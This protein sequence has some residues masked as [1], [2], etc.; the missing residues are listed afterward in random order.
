MREV[1]VRVICAVIVAVIF[2]SSIVAVRYLNTDFGEVDT[3]QV[4][5]ASQLGNI[6]GLL[7]RPVYATATNPQPAVVLAHGI[8]GSKQYLSGIALELARNNIVAL[9]IDLLGHGGSDG[10]LADGNEDASLGMLAAVRYL[11]AQDFVNSSAIGLVGHSLGAGAARATAVA[12]EGIRATVLIAGGFGSM[13]A[14]PVYGA[15]NSTFPQNLL[16]A[17]GKYD[18]LFNL[19]ELKKETLPPIFETPTEAATDTLYGNFS[20]HNARKLVT[21]PTTHLFEPVDP[22]IGSET[23]KWL[24]SALQPTDLDENSRPTAGLSVYRDTSILI[25]LVTLLG[26]LLLISTTVFS[27]VHYPKIKRNIQMRTKAQSI[28]DWKVLIV[29][30]SLS[31]ILFFPMT[32]VGLS[33]NIPPVIFGS[34][35]AWWTLAIA[36]TGLIVV[37]LWSRFSNSELNVRAALAQAFDI[38]ALFAAVLIFV[39]LYLLATFVSTYMVIDFG[40]IVPFFRALTPSTRIPVFLMFIPFFFVYFTVEGIYL[41]ELRQ[42]SWRKSAVLTALANLAKTVGVKVTP[43]LVV[44][45]LQ[46]VPFVLFG[47]QLFPSFAGFLIEFLWLLIPI[48]AISTACSWWFYR[49][50]TRIGLG[51]VFNALV[52]AWIAASLFPF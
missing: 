9:T 25:G 27:I 49:S 10:R 24:I 42:P 45:S 12:H 29:W 40:I 28:R 31:L 1:N 26:L 23:I 36:A 17:I 20:S 22:V 7:Y 47:F 6:S 41:H 32:L 38:K 46:Y 3:Q 35:I 21:P 44:L 16:V 18:V 34:S 48:F 5:V 2:V 14:D 51:A 33:I 50:T 11:E 4:S 15:F 8:S 13:V 43:Y 30:G 52:F 19:N 37:A 39:A